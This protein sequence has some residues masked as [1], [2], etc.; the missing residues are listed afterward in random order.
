[1][2]LVFKMIATAIN[3]LLLLIAVPFCIGGII[4]QI[5]N[6][7]GIANNEQADLG[8]QDALDLPFGIFPAGNKP[9]VFTESSIIS[10]AGPN[11]N[12]AYALANAPTAPAFVGEY[13]EIYSVPIRTVYSQVYWTTEPVQL[14]PQIVSR[15]NGSVMAITGFETDIVRRQPGKPDQPVFTYEHYNHHWN[16]FIMGANAE[17]TVSKGPAQHNKPHVTFRVRNPDAAV[18]A[19]KPLSPTI[20]VVTVFSEGNGNE[21]RKSFHGYPPNFVQLVESPAEFHPTL[22]FINTKNPTGDGKPIG[23]PLPHNNPSPANAD[24]SELLEC[25]CTDRIVKLPPSF[26]LQNTNVC[27]MEPVSSATECFTALPRMQ[28]PISSNQTVTDPSLPSG[29]LVVT[30][31][32]GGYQAVYN[33]ASST[34]L[35][36]GAGPSSVLV[37][38]ASSLVQLTVELDATSGLANITMSGPSSAWFGKFCWC[39]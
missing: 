17:A 30:S 11:M 21:H 33:F 3:R 26:I 39:T 13:F 31:K 18:L 7:N 35:C 28:I 22:M 24:Y 12:G 34:R 25:P 16:L 23:G 29:C 37:G 4:V 36:G 14:P 38:N 10:N 8:N 2:L 5:P 32:T 20:P 27:P 19:S 1:M 6:E 9:S 15:F